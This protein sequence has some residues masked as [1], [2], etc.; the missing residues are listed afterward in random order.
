MT[1]NPTLALTPPEFT[2]YALRSK[3]LFIFKMKPEKVF[4][5]YKNLNEPGPHP[6]E[7]NEK[8]P[9]EKKKYAEKHHKTREPF[10]IVYDS[11]AHIA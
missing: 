3:W 6:R 10:K 2:G 1:K 4:V 9:Y 11:F 7:K 8:R 5:R